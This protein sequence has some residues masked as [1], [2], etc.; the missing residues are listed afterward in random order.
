LDHQSTKLFKKEKIV[1]L[2]LFV[3]L[4]KMHIFSWRSSAMLASMIH[5]IC[6]CVSPISKQKIKSIAWW[7]ASVKYWNASTKMM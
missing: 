4:A 6:T 1:N 7:I 3:T 5:H 2:L